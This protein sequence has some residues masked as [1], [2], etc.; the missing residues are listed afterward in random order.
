ML[1]GAEQTCLANCVDRFLDMNLITMK[2]LNSMRQ[3]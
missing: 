1:E 3:A 2:H